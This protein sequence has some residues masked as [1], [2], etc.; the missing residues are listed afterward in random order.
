MD[1]LFLVSNWGEKIYEKYLGNN[2]HKDKSTLESC[3]LDHRVAVDH[4]HN[5]HPPKK[6][7]KTGRR[8]SS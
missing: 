7:K 3:M 4:Q 6:R 8:F 2:I 1:V 5:L